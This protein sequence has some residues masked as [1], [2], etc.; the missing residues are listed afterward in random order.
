MLKKIKRVMIWIVL[1]Y[2]A[3]IGW[4]LYQIHMLQVGHERAMKSFHEWAHER[5]IVADGGK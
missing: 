4:R 2:A 1:V 3:L 5:G